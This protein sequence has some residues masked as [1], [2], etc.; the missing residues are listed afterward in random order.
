MMGLPDGRKSFK[1]D[2]AVFIQYR[3]V[4][5]THLGSQPLC[6][7]KDCA[8]V[9]VARLKKHKNTIFRTYSRG[10]LYK[11]CL[12]IEHVVAIK[13]AEDHFFRSNV[14]FS[15]RVHRKIRPK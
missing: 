12:V 6:R 15:Y 1:I 13:I 5:D 2:L 11:L 10:A 3:R 4:T 14:Y 7:S 9:Y 8:Y